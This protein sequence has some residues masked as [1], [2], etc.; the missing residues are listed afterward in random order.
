[1]TI[2]IVSPASEGLTWNARPSCG[3]IACVEYGPAN[4][5]AAPS[6]KPAMPLESSRPLLRA[7]EQA[8]VDR[9]S[10]EEAEPVEPERRVGNHL[11]LRLGSVEDRLDLVGRDRAVAV[12]PLAGPGHPLHEH[13]VDER[14]QVSLA[15]P[16]VAAHAVIVSPVERAAHRADATSKLARRRLQPDA[17]RGDEDPENRAKQERPRP[18]AAHPAEI[19]GEPDAGERD[20]DQ[21]EGDIREDAARVGADESH[22]VEH[23]REHEE[24]EERRY[25]AR[26]TAARADRRKPSAIGTIRVV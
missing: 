13:L 15:Q 21:A 7:D 5:P 9:G 3:R 17:D 14:A 4:M 22:G 6:R 19:R 11:R 20:R 16:D 8:P 18:R 25:E 1:M 26:G 24:D 2:E 10:L 23:G 12:E